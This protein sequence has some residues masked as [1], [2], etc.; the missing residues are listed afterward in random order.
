[1]NIKELLTL[2]TTPI[3]PEIAK[4]VIENPEATVTDIRTVAA[5]IGNMPGMGVAHPL[6]Q[7]A[8][9]RE[10]EIVMSAL[11]LGG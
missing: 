6:Y 4:A 7:A 8:H 11:E 5:M 9:K 3:T 10:A 1:M 2:Y